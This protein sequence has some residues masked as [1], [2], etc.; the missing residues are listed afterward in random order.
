MFNWPK[1]FLFMLNRPNS[2]NE[3]NISLDEHGI[4]FNWPNLLIN[5][6]AK[7]PYYSFDK[8]ISFVEHL[9][10]VWLSTEN[11]SHVQLT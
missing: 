8:H 1:T 3:H 9:T 10:L 7:M 2:N 4:M 5:I 11:L 6:Y